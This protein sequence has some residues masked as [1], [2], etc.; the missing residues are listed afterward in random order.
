MKSPCCWRW[1]GLLIA[2]VLAWGVLGLYSTSGAAPQSGQPPFANAIDQRAEMVRELQEI[3]ALL[4]EQNVILRAGADKT[5]NVN[6]AAS[7]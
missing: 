7:R 3:K 5:T 1:T 2:N 4:K 6:P